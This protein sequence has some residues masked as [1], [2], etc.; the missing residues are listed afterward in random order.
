MQKK[1][2]SSLLVSTAL[3]MTA[4][5]DSKTAETKTAPAAATEAA[6]PAASAEFDYK[7]TPKKI[8]DNVWCFFGALDKPTKEN[9]G[10]M[11]NNC[12]VK[13]VMLL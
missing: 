8:N 3:L 2:L 12:Y 7:L 13:L 10:N 6:T 4:C 11:A 1:I 9:A 5:S